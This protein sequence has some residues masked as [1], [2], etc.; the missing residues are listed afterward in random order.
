ML[1]HGIYILH[2]KP[3]IVALWGDDAWQAIA[4]S[5]NKPD[6]ALWHCAWFQG[7]PLR[8][9]NLKYKFNQLKRLGIHPL[10][11]VNSDTEERYR[12]LFG[13]PGFKS[14]A[15][16]FVDEENY[17]LQDSS[18]KLYDAI[19]AA[20]LNNFKR[21]PLAA[22]IK[23]LYV[24]TYKSGAKQWDLHQEYPVMKHASF[25]SQWIDEKDKNTLYSQSE[26][27]LC[28]SKEE[29]PMLAS[30]EYLLNGL[31]VVSTPSKG[32]RDKYYE[33][34]YCQIVK[35]NPNAV[36]QGVD[37]MIKR[38]I[39]PSDIRETTIKKLQK[40]RVKYVQVLSSYTHKHYNWQLNEADIMN[41]WFA[42]P[43]KNFVPLAQYTS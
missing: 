38:N 18:N 16:V 43:T 31:P 23:R 26:V 42:K 29:G 28:L 10:L 40:D 33:D 39:K 7:T 11:V 41:E 27:G 9:A 1:F 14:S 32:G 25:N 22:Q 3:K 13:I 8:M 6:I 12:K 30:L 34:D 2:D 5:N 4:N 37:V 17:A 19:Y 35:P 15:Y 21:I 24:M 36:K 20:Q